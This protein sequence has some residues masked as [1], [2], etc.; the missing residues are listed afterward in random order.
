[1][2]DV[3]I[4]QWL[5]LWSFFWALLSP[6]TCW[7]I[8]LIGDFFIRKIGFLSPASGRVRI[9]YGWAG[10]GLSTIFI[11][12]VDLGDGAIKTARTELYW[13]NVLL[14]FLILGVCAWLLRGYVRILGVIIGITLYATNA[15]YWTYFERT[16]RV[17]VAWTPAHSE[18]LSEHDRTQAKHPVA[19]MFTGRPDQGQVI[20]SDAIREHLTKR[21][22]GPFE[23]Q[24]VL[25]Y[26]WGHLRY[27]RFLSVDGVQIPVEAFGRT[28]GWHL[29]Q[30][31]IFPNRWV[32][33]GSTGFAY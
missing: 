25:E 20:V 22:A 2:R 4:W 6:F 27:F 14:F 26:T 16:E 18:E 10:L 11:G 19:L 13:V 15:Y 29:G 1:M 23:A 31:S 32:K 33:I 3:S 24:V 8:I 30:L 9:L 17:Q 28:R 5:I 7:L 12:A 21:G